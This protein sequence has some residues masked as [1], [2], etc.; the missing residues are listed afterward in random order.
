MKA[1]DRI[2]L[3]KEILKD[4]QKDPYKVMVSQS[5]SKSTKTIRPTDKENYYDAYEKLHFTPI[6]LIAI[7]KKYLIQD[8]KNIEASEEE[9]IISFIYMI[10]ECDNWIVDETEVIPED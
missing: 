4:I 9:V 10:Q 8:L 7:L 3:L 1:K 6:E 5:L 2:E